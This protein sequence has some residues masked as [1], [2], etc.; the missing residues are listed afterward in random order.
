[1]KER[2]LWFILALILPFCIYGQLDKQTLN[3]NALKVDVVSDGNLEEI[4]DAAL[5][6]YLNY[7]TQIWLSARD[8]NDS[9]CVAAQLYR[10]SG[11]D[12]QPGPISNNPNARSNYNRVWKINKTMVD[13]FANGLYSG[14]VPAP[15]ADWPAHGDTAQ[16]ESFYIAPF[17]DVNGNGYYNPLIDGDYPCILGDQA[18]FYVFNDD[19]VHTQSGG[20]S[21]GVEITGLVYA[22][23]ANSFLDSV[24]FVQYNIRN[25]TKE[26][27]NIRVGAMADFDIGNSI[28]DICGTLVDG[29]TVFAYNGD[30]DDENPWGFG[31]NPPITGLTVRTGIRPNIYDGID[32]DKD[33]CVDGVRDT[34]GICQPNDSATN[35]FENW[36]LSGSAYYNNTSGGV[37]SAISGNPDLAIH[38]ANYLTPKWRNGFNYVVD[39]PSGYLNQS[40][41]DGFR[42]DGTGTPTIHVYPGNSYDTSGTLHPSAP[43]NWFESPANLQDKR[44]VAG[45]GIRDTL[46]V[47]DELQVRFAL[48]MTRDT[49][50]TNSYDVAGAMATKINQFQEPTP[51]CAS[52]G[53]INIVENEELAEFVVYPNPANNELRIVSR[54]L[55]SK[56]GEIYNINGQRIKTFSMDESGIAEL[57]ISYLPTGL[58]VVKIGNTAKRFLISR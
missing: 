41:G 6:K 55:A 37:L 15:I 42:P 16:G 26:L 23:K 32:N 3:I 36:K 19:T 9:L 50:N 49:N 53:L 4:K 54:K 51:S 10:Q 13:S 7:T 34:N 43:T 52:A 28:D 58:Y 27:Q 35:T 1:M 44:M 20:L 8:V 21:L 33:G 30:N 18:I 5:D 12:F 29:N 47:G 25:K 2:N 17:V 38:Y 31:L 57:N 45:L 24:V 22:Y 56:R 14:L 11:R 40:N 39:D 48:F 46:S